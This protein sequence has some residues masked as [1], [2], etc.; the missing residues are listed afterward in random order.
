M[1]QIDADISV[2][3]ASLPSASP[4]P[5]RQMRLRAWRPLRRGNL[6]GFAVIDLPNGLQISDVMVSSGKNGLFARLPQRPVVR[7]G[8]LSRGDG[9][10][11]GVMYDAPIVWQSRDLADEFSRRVIE[12]VRAFAPADLEDE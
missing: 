12:L 3:E 1:S 8:Q 11:G 9:P 5:R 6:R 2:D 4:H 10:D 7:N